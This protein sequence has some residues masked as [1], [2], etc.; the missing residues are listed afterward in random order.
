MGDLGIARHRRHKRP[1]RGRV[2]R[3]RKYRQVP[4]QADPAQAA[5]SQPGRGCVWLHA[6][7][8]RE[9]PGDGRLPGGGGAIVALAPQPVAW[10]R[11]EDALAERVTTLH[12]AA[13]QAL[14][15]EQNAW[16]ISRVMAGDLTAAVA[17][18]TAWCVDHVIDV[19]ATN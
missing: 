7:D 4:R 14:N 1:D 10:R 3:V 19:A 9:E 15:G 17:A 16:V 5:R 12:G 11:H 18:L 6:D 8:G 13:S 2:D